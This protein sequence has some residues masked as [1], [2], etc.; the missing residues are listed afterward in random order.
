[1]VIEYV[2][3]GH[4]KGKPIDE[5]LVKDGIKTETE[6][7]RIEAHFKTFEK[8]KS[9][10]TRIAKVDLSSTPDFTGTINK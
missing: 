10:K 2:L 6:A 8:Y 9:W 7:K 1:M 5:V 3:W 4:P